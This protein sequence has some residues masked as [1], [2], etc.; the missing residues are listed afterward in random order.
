ME[1]HS[2]RAAIGALLLICATSV[3]AE[4]GVT[5]TTIVLGQSAAFSGPAQQLG[6]QMRDGMKLWFDH[7]NRH[8]GIHGRKIHLVT[9]DD[10]Y[11]STLAAENTRKLIQEDKVFALVG[12]VGTPT[13]KASLPIFTAAKVPFVGPFTGAELL[14]DPFNRYIFNVRAS[15]YNETDQIV[16]Q[17]LTTG[18]KR[19]AVFYQNDSYGQ[20]GL[21]GVKIAVSKRGGKIV[22]TGTVER[23]TVD[24]AK[25]VREIVPTRPDAVIMISAYK[26]IAAF[27]RAAKKDGYNG[28]FYNV[29][30]VGSTALSN[31]LGKDGHGVA[32]SQ[33]VPFP[34][35]RKVQVVRE[36]HE[37]ARKAKVDINFSSLEGFLVAKVT[38]EGLRRVGNRPL[39]RDRF[40]EAMETMNNAD[41]GGFLVNYSRKDHNG[42]KFVDL[43]IIAR[44]GGFRN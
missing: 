4:V 7:I 22:S 44:D 9:R 14:R 37:F 27:I 28:Q 12:Y 41:F 18:S 34:W 17:L 5:A 25:A 10:G 15:Y 3:S 39:T 30:F 13:S 42:S 19:F 40:I 31:E 8:G 36:F 1:R 38:V 20:A 29:S 33:V 2:T 16:Q 32:I 43:T 26:S 35:S 6:I 24:V 21:E 23:N 11:E